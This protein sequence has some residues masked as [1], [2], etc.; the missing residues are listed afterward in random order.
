MQMGW[1]V[2]CVNVSP[3]EKECEREGKKNKM[4]EW[5]KTFKCRQ[6]GQHLLLTVFIQENNARELSIV[7]ALKTDGFI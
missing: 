3:S 4:G 7:R 6:N 1:A 2:V 5:R